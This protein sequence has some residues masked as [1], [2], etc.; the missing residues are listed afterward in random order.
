[1]KQ[2]FILSFLVVFLFPSCSSNNEVPSST[3]KLLNVK[4][5]T[6][7]YDDIVISNVYNNSFSGKINFEYNNNNQIIKVKGGLINVPTLNSLQNWV[8]YNDAEDQI[9]YLPD[10]KIRVEHSYNNDT[11]PYTKEFTII[12]GV[13]TERSVLNTYPIL[14][15]TPIQYTYE[16][17]NNIITERK[18]GD[19]YRTFHMLNGNL[20][21]VVQLN[22]D[23]N[24]EI[25]GKKEYV[26]LNYDDK[27]NLLK[28]KYYI[29]GALFKAFSNNNYQRIEINQYSYNNNEYVLNTFWQGNFTLTYNSN[30]IA[31]IFEQSCD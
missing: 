25:I 18:N 17:S 7:V 3:C 16:Y 6:L 2:I 10:N 19:V 26:F 14:Y 13:L 15:T 9:I 23:T 29:N 24:G 31:E 20:E 22:H 11:K 5:I 12:G 28:G 27:E 30:N 8:L 21:K 4:T 1:M